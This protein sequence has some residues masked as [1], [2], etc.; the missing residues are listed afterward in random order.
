MEAGLICYCGRDSGHESHWFET[1]K[2]KL[3]QLF[4]PKIL[5]SCLKF[6]VL[7]SSRYD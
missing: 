3:L 7:E 6:V 5:C 4:F 1:V 2:A